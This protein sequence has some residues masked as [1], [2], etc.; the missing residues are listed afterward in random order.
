MVEGRASRCVTLEP[1]YKQSVFRG[2]EGVG[3][4]EV[5]QRNLEATVSAGAEKN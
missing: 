4:E 5:N 3:E 2:V 1:L